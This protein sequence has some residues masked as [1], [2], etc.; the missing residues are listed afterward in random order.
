MSVPKQL[1]MNRPY[2]RRLMT[3]VRRDP[4]IVHVSN[5]MRTAGVMNN[6]ILVIYQ[7]LKIGK[8]HNSSL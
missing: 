8:P 7:R 3:S 2:N 1:L 5:L 6:V 4:M